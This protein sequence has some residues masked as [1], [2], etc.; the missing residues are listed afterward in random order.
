MH[1]ATSHPSA[2]HQLWL[3]EEES[4]HIHGWDFSHIQGRYQEEDDLP[5]DYDALIRQHLKPWMRLMDYDTGGGEYLLTL[6][7]PYQLTAATE[8]YPP[9]VRLCQETL[10]PLGIDLRPCEDASSIPFP[11]DSFDL[12]INRH[13]NFHPPELLRLLKHGGLFIT[14]QVGADNDRDLVEMVLPGTPLPFPQARLAIQHQ[15][16]QEAGF[17]LLQA[18]EAFRPIIFFDVGAFVWFAR[19]ISWEFP[20]F[21]VEAC[22]PRL[23]DMQRRLETTGAIEGTIH[24]Y[25]MLARKP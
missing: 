20:G 17:Q 9:N 4:A 24:R 12:I 19:I 16:L 5:W 1:F 13:G 14:Q 22:F 2:L 18:E 6:K 11:D 21:S 10:C 23:M 8:G 7:H 15:C 3:Q 25:M